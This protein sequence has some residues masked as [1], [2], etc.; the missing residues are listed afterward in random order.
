MRI[1]VDA[2]TGGDAGESGSDDD[3]DENDETRTRR[4][5]PVV[6]DCRETKLQPAAAA[7]VARWCCC[8]QLRPAG[9]GQAGGLDQPARARR[10]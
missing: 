3:G 4:Q 1:E 7:A 8:A 2:D 5:I 10:S 9:S 6:V